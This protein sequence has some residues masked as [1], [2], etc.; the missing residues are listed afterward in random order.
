M[1]LMKKLIQLLAKENQNRLLLK[2]YLVGM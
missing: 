1:K 2:A